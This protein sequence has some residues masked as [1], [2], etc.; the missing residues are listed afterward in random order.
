M[1]TKILLASAAA[2][3]AGVFASNAQ[4]YSANIVG[5]VNVP[6]TGGYNLVANPLDDNNGDQLTNLLTTLPNKAQ[7]VTW[8]GTG[9][10]TAITYNSSSGWGSN[11]QLPPGV[12]F[13]IKNGIASSPVL[14]N[15]F[16]GQVGVGG[17]AVGQANTNNGTASGGSLAAG[18]ALAGSYF[19]YSG[20]ATVDTT[21]IALTQVLATKSQLISWNTAGQTYNSADVKGASGWGSSFTINPGQGFFIKAQTAGSNWVQTLQ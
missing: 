10:N 13:F 21:N 8:N 20:D 18:Y 1:R 4:V 19:P 2:L 7:V 15:T 14:T 9:F 3:A 17:Y 16:V 12:G 5:Y 11:I 6:L